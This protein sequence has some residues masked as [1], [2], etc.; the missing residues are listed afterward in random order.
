VVCDDEPSIVDLLTATLR[1]G[2]FE[3]ASTT[4]GEEALALVESFKPDLVLLDVMMPG[5]DGFEVARRMRQRTSTPFL[6]LTAKDSLDERIMGLTIGADDYITK[7]FSLEEVVAR[8]RAVLR[9]TR[10]KEVVANPSRVV[11][12]DL[13]IDEETHEVFKAGEPVGLSPTEFALLR[14]LMLNPNKVLSKAQILDHVWN[15]D[16]TGD[17]NVVESYISYLR[18]K[19]D[20]SEPKLIHTLRSV[21][22]ILRQ[23][24]V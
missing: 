16:F 6:F 19:V 20:T 11:F 24:R 17:A 3:V 7:P 22:Y 12:A 2:G 5:L 18:K 13:E 21:G 10:N 14:Y 15:Y 9:R 23:P 1:H 8:C 4:D